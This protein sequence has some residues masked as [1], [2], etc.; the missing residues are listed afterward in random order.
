[1]I[2]RAKF[3]HSLA[4]SGRAKQARQAIGDK[5]WVVHSKA[6]GDGQRAL[7]YLAPYVYRVAISNRRLIKCEPGLDGLGRVTFTF[8]KSGSRG[9]RTMTVT[10][11][12]FI[13][14]FLQHVLPSGFQKVRHYGFAHPQRGI[15]IEWLKM[16]KMLVT[17]TLALVYVLVV[18]AKPL[19][20]VRTPS[21]PH[22]GQPMTYL[23]FVPAPTD[24]V[25]IYDS[26]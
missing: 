18:A 12:E 24:S 17:T 13:R 20:I 7:R 19:P 6:V 10:A 23:G 16:F 4:A 15:D 22:C 11:D 14:R 26:S 2:Y 5:P 8:R 25:M 1:M 21:C 9:W 3:L